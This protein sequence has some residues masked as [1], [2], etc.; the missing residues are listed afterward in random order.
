ML[1][2]SLALDQENA[3]QPTVMQ[4][5]AIKDEKGVREGYL[6]P[7]SLTKLDEETRL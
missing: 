6:I 5:G 2:L 3:L 1:T 4:H 7:K